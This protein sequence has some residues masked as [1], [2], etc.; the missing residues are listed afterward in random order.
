MATEVLKRLFTV[1]EFHRMAEAGVFGEDDRVELLDGEIVQMAA[2]G[3]RHA[4]CVSRLNEWFGEHVREAAI[5]SVQNPLVLSEQIELYPDIALLKRRPDFY[6]Q[7]HPGPADVLLVVEV[8]DTTGDYDCGVKVP[9][10]ARTGIPAVWVVDL[11]DG[12]IDIYSQPQGDQYR[13]HQ[14]VGSG[15][16]LEIPGVSDQRIAVDEVLT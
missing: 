12:A 5:V 4:A 3:S 10:C 13:D 1:D 6:S 16:S 9:R 7:S 14:R 15:Q 2:I 8:A 11:R